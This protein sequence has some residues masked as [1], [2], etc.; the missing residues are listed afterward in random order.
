M[1]VAVAT[2]AGLG[3]PRAS[4]DPLGSA[5]AQAAN[6][7][8]RIQTLG[9]QE[10][11]LSE[12]YDQATLALQ[13]A[14]ARVTQASKQ[15]QAAQAEERHARAALTADAVS[16]YENGGS[17]ATTPTHENSQLGAADASMVQHEYEGTLANAQGDDLD[18]YHLLALQA[19]D[20]E[21]SLQQAQTDAQNTLNQ[22]NQDR[23]AATALAAQLQ[24]AYGQAKGQVATLLD[25]QQAAQQAAQQQAAQQRLLAAQTAARQQAA[26]KLDSAPASVPEARTSGLGTTSTTTAAPRSTTAVTAPAPKPSVSTAAAR[27][28]PTYGS[29]GGGAA[30]QVTS[31][32]VPQGSG[33]GEAIAA[34][35]SRIGDPYVYGAAGPDAFDCSGLVQW[36]FAQAGISLPHF[37]GAQYAD[38]VHIPMSALEPGDLV[39]FA[40]PG[41]HVAI[42]IGNGQIVEAPHSG[43][44]VWITG[45]YSDFVLA[46]RVA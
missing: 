26:T 31:A 30:P 21:K 33:V 22:V 16:V 44:T 35:E 11:A 19:S 23:Q 25:Q 14:Q 41:A 29:S 10:D 20:A 17:T 28:A 27:P 43:A 2:L 6:L 36:A 3:I 42:Y 32:P 34:A 46:G 18:H 1:A 15:V 4:A 7:L 12:K 38:T 24:Q 45:M 5:Q 8:A 39:F 40:D 37:S 9:L 13:S